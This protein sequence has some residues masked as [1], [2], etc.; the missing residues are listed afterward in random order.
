MVFSWSKYEIWSVAISMTNKFQISFTMNRN[1]IFSLNM[2]GSNI[3]EFLFGSFQFI[4]LGKKIFQFNFYSILISIK[5]TVLEIIFRFLPSLKNFNQLI[6]LKQNPNL[7]RNVCNC[8]Y[9]LN[10]F[11]S[12]LTRSLYCSFKVVHSR[13]ICSRWSFLVFRFTI[14]SFNFWMDSVIVSLAM[15]RSTFSV[16]NFSISCFL[17]F[18]KKNIWLLW[19]T[20]QI[21]L[22]QKLKS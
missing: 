12:V 22:I 13:L 3:G 11:P 16:F 2:F 20:L 8:K 7:N 10:I 5:S 9:L 18:C 15:Y 17:L 21:K 19:F 4:L 1:F 14:S 6:L